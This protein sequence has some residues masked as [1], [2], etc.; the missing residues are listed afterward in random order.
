MESR[1]VGKWGKQAPSL[2]QG[3]PNVMFEL[4]MILT[5]LKAIEIYQRKS[6]RKKKANWASFNLLIFQLQIYTFLGLWH[7]CLGPS[8]SLDTFIDICH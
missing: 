5:T 3:A 2:G 4:V 1:Q 6:E 8:R 7:D